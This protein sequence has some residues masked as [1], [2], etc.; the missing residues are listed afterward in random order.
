VINP[1]P[2]CLCQAPIEVEQSTWSSIK[3]MYR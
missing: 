1:E 3:A 2:E